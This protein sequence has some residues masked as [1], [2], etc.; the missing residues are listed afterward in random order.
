[1]NCGT[2]VCGIESFSNDDYTNHFTNL[3]GELIDI[4]HFIIIIN[5]D[6]VNSKC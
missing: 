1:M 3:L 4:N 2:G 6:S 5:C